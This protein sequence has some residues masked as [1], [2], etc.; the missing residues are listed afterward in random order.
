MGN[1]GIIYFGQKNAIMESFAEMHELVK[2]KHI[3][4]LCNI[5]LDT[6]RNL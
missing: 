4:Y 6:R 5:F 3:Q 2:G 1:L